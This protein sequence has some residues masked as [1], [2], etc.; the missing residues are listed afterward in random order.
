MELS[1]YI[2]VIE[3]FPKPGISFKDITTLL[4]DKDAYARLIHRL[5]DKVRGF[6]PDLIVGPEARGFVIGAPLAFALGC[7]FVPLRRPGKLPYETINIG[8]GLEYGS[9]EM[10]IHKD[11]VEKGQRVIVADDLLATGG[12]A[13]AGCKLVEQLGGRIVACSFAIELLDLKGR[14]LLTDYF[15]DVAITF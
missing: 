10:Q 6:E 1:Q 4:R 5:A 11:G 7:G 9:G 8:Y 3:D 13:L 14:E 12:T 2:R 15:V